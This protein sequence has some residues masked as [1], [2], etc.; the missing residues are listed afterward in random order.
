M[1]PWYLI[2]Y[3]RC[4]SDLHG[5]DAYQYLVYQLNKTVRNHP[6]YKQNYGPATVSDSCIKKIITAIAD[7]SYAV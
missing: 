3:F 7:S 4:N 1:E 5:N 2:I 6:V